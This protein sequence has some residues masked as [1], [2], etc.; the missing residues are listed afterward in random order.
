M[1]VLLNK[2]EDVMIKDIQL[3][4]EIV[5]TSENKVGILANISKILADHDINI[6]GVAGY[7]AGNEAK[8]MVV[9]DDTLRATD[10]LKKAGFKSIKENEVI[11]VDLVNKPGAMKNI[12]AKLAADNIDI[13]YTYGTIC[14]SGCPAKIILSTSAN[15]KAFVLLKTK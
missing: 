4:K 3:G 8:I 11:M 13:K 15:E 1:I 2:K 6:E 14:S 7:A 9:T 5:V 12:T 10:A